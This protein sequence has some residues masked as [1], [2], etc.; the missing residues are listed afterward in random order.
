MLR[1]NSQV[2]NTEI[3]SKNIFQPLTELNTPIFNRFDNSSAGVTFS[4]GIG[5]VLDPDNQ[6]VFPIL[7][8]ESSTVS[9][10]PKNSQR[11]ENKLSSESGEELTLVAGY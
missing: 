11:T 10:L 5:A 6:F 9:L 4:D 2:D 8:A 7:R 1:D 3:C